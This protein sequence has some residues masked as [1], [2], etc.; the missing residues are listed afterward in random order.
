VPQA[1]RGDRRTARAYLS[2]PNLAEDGRRCARRAGYRLN[3]GEVGWWP[4]RRRTGRNYSSS[5]PNCPASLRCSIVGVVHQG[6]L[7]VTGRSQHGEFAPAA[8]GRV[9]TRQRVGWPLSGPARRG[10]MSLPPIPPRTTLE[11]IALARAW[12]WSAAWRLVQ[13]TRC[14]IMWCRNIKGNARRFG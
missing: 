4:A 13:R 11:A 2:D 6:G 1:W 14:S 9:E 3:G 7:S 8:L 12:A 10:K 5:A